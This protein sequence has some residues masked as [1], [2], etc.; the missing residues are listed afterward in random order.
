MAVFASFCSQTELGYDTCL[1]G[2]SLFDDETTQNAENHMSFVE[3]ILQVYEKTWE[4]VVCVVD[5]NCSTNHSVGK[6]V[7]KITKVARAIVI[8][9]VYKISLAQREV[10]L[11]KFVC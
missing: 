11:R 5:D 6:I 7:G 3:F 8:I 10:T 2:F 1:L 9:W 4:N